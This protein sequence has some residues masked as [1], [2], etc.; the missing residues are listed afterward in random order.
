MNEVIKIGVGDTWC[1]VVNVTVGIRL[2]Q[3]LLEG[4]LDFN[5]GL[6]ARRYLNTEICARV[7]TI[8]YFDDGA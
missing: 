4:P 7:R 8:A 1:L 6:E 2:G 5:V 3:E